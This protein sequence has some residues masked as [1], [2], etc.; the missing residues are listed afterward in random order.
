MALSC[1]RI[2]DEDDVLGLVH[3][4]ECGETP[5]LG[6]IDGRLEGEVKILQALDH[7]DLGAFLQHLDAPC[8]LVRGDKIKIGDQQLQLLRSRLTGQC[9]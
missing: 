5:D 9:E 3:E 8:P 6:L 7:R 2:T 4:A 1:P